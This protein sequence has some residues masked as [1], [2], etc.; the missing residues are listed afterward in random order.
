[1]RDSWSSPGQAG[2]GDPGEPAGGRERRR[3]KALLLLISFSINMTSFDMAWTQAVR[4]KN[5]KM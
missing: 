1:M 2:V 4:R 5:L 3:L